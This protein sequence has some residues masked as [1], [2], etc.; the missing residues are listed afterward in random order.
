MKRYL[1][2]TLAMFML[3]SS[4]G[5]ATTT[6]ES[7]EKETVVAANT[8]TTAEETEYAPDLPNVTYEGEDFKFYIGM[9]PMLTT[10]WTCLPM[11]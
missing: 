11:N 4:C 5:T 3:L 1:T 10:P 6:E 8:E 7:N 9:A 2:F